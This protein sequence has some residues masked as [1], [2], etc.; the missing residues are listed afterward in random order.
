MVSLGTRILPGSV[1][2][3]C[4]CVC[5]CV[6]CACLFVCVSV[7]VQGYEYIPG[8]GSLNRLAEAVVTSLFQE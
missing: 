2:L 8:N 7:C 5:V 3:Y 4:E 6:F 1:C